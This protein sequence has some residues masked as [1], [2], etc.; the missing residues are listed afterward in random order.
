M[1]TQQR[2]ASGSPELPHGTRPAAA[3]IRARLSGWIIVCL[4]GAAVATFFLTLYAVKHYSMPIGWDTPRYLSQTNFVAE[5]GLAGV[6]HLLPPPTKTLVS[7]AGFPVV[8]LSLSSLFGVST[9]KVAAVAPVGAVVALA[10]AAGAFVSWSLRRGP[11]E[12]AAVAAVVGT[13][14]VVIRLMAP[15]TYTDNIFAGALLLASFVPILSAVRDG[16]GYVGAVLLMVAAGLAHGPSFAL[17][18]ATLALV[19]LAF[20]PHSW[21]L[22]RRRRQS[23]FATPS[24]RLGLLIG[25]SGALAAAGIYGLLRTPPDTPKLTRGEL[26]KKL[27]EDL[28]LYRFALSLPIAGIGLAALAAPLAARRDDRSQEVPQERFTAGFVLVALASWAAVLLLAVALYALGRNAPAHRSLAFLLPLPILVAIGLL[29][30]GRLLARR[31][32]MA[33]VAFVL[34]GIGA[35]AFFGYRTLYIDLPRDRGVEW[36]EPGKV[37]DAATAVAYLQAAGVPNDAP[38]VYVIDDRGPNPLSFVPEMMYIMRSVMPPERIENSFAYV[39]DPARYLAGERTFR[40]TP[41]T[42][43]ANVQRFW[44]TVERLLPRDPVALLLSSYNLDYGT[45]AEQHPDWVVAPNVIALNGPRPDED[46]PAPPIPSAPRTIV[47]GA[48]LGGGTLVVLTLLGL[49][50]AAALLPR[51]LRSFELLALSPAVGIGFLILGGVL[52]D[53]LGVRLDGVGGVAAVAVTAAAGLALA[54]RRLGAGAAGAFPP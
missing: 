17:M 9:F 53:A 44:P 24:A 46:V 28:P 47:Q 25:S 35:L 52:I 13:S 18:M 41:R 7:R 42:Y 54:W 23:L 31:V 40:D 39:G 3:Y 19:A 50:W 38:V 30:V 20:A 16:E 32:R 27:R 26:S 36:M 29:A 49:G 8:I 14:S 2:T 11:L 10:L 4:V 22:W 51:G 6:P 48:L 43:N 5:R 45:V 12:L 33:G 37:Q 1:R 34:L 21:T 15:E